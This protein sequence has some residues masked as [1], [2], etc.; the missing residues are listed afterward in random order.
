MSAS[1]KKY[2]LNVIL[3]LV[4]LLVIFLGVLAIFASLDKLEWNKVWEWTSKATVVAGIL[5]VLNIVIA[6]LVSMLP[7]KK[8]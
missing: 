8:K 5:A 6:G 7:G 1:G 3:A 2:T 4:G